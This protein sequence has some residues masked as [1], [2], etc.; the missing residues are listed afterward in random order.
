VVGQALIGSS[1]RRI[2]V[3]LDGV[4]TGMKLQLDNGATVEALESVPAGGKTVRVR[5]IESLLWP[6]PSG[7]EEVIEARTVFGIYTDDTTSVV[8]AI[9]SDQLQATPHPQNR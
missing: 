5:Y 7:T 3:N 2:S 9:V 6:V 8:R 4:K 1:V